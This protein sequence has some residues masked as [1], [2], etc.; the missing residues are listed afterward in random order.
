MNEKITQ[1]EG[2]LVLLKAEQVAEILNIGLSKAYQLMQTGEIPT[3][4]F[5]RSVRVRQSDL[6]E[7]IEKCWSGWK[8]L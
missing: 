2:H 3:I 7:F 4:R 5:N 6:E 8:D 1:S